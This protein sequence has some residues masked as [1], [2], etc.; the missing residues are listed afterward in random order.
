MSAQLTILSDEQIS[1]VSGGHVT[2]LGVM[3]FLSIP[4]IIMGLVEFT[5][6]VGE[7]CNEGWLADPSD[8]FAQGVYAVVTS[9]VTLW[10]Y[11]THD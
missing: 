5:N 3:F 1:Q 7:K 2:E 8:Y 4:H 9:P 10:N 11:V 6:Y